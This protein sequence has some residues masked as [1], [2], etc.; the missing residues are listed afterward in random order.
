M[1]EN[2]RQDILLSQKDGYKIV[3]QGIKCSALFC[4][5]QKRRENKEGRKS[6]NALKERKK[7]RASDG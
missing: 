3:S 1:N 2:S 4:S 6:N 5:A 7:H